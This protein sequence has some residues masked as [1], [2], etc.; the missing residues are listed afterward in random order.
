MFLYA[1]VMDD[2]LTGKSF[3]VCNSGFRGASSGP[4]SGTFLCYPK[5]FLSFSSSITV[6][7]SLPPGVSDGSGREKS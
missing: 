4:V 1:S 2:L 7:M 3:P 6:K 5:R